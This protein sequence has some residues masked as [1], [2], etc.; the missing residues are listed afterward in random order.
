MLTML[1]VYFIMLCFTMFRSGQNY[2]D[3]THCPN[4]VLLLANRCTQLAENV[5]VTFL[6]R[7]R[8]R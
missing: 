3:K 4:G 2:M 7:S 8:V 1:A 5:A 6:F